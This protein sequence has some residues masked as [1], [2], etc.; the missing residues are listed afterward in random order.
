MC[1]FCRLTVVIGFCSLI[2][3]TAVNKCMYNQKHEIL[4]S[5]VLL[6]KPKGLVDVF[7]VFIECLVCDFDCRLMFN[8]CCYNFYGTGFSKQQ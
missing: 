8:V 4:G 6:I 2:F 7:W 1:T 5:Q 3:M